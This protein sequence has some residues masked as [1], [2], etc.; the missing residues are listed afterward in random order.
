[1]NQLYLA[2]EAYY[3]ATGQYVAFSEGNSLQ[4][5]Y[6]YEWT[7]A[8]DGEAWKVTGVQT[9][10]YLNI[11][12]IIYTKV[13]FSFLALYNSTFAQNMI[14]Y[15]QKMMPLPTDGYCDGANSSGQTVPGNGSGTNGLI[16][17]AAH[18]AINNQP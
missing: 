5:R 10:E 13:A 18:Y 2:H 14:I 11:N 6:I 12:P 17:D 1:M 7:V 15:L 8:P 16:L 3:N 4:A 9:S